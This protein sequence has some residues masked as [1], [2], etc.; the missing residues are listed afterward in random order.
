MTKEDVWQAAGLHVFLGSGAL[1]GTPAFPQVRQDYEVPKTYEFVDTAILAVGDK[2]IL[3]I[4]TKGGKISMPRSVLPEASVDPDGA[5]NV[6]GL[7][8][9]GRR[10]PAE[11]V[12]KDFTSVEWGIGD[13]GIITA[14]SALKLI[15]V[16]KDLLWEL[17]MCSSSGAL[18]NAVSGAVGHTGGNSTGRRLLRKG[19]LDCGVLSSDALCFVWERP[20]VSLGDNALIAA[21]RFTPPFVQGGKMGVCALLGAL[22]PKAAANDVFRLYILFACGGFAAGTV[23]LITIVRVLIIRMRR[24]LKDKGTVAA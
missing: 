8:N 14:V 6:S 3:E 19:A 12:S 10:D 13:K 15:K 2:P 24:N 17:L 5:P 4:D 18:A 22:L 11:Y 21:A 1:T 9:G 20:P 16:K 23:V 7:D